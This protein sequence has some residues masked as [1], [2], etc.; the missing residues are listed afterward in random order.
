MT[1][2]EVLIIKIHFNHF[3]RKIRLRNQSLL[4]PKIRQEQNK[5]SVSIHHYTGGK[6]CNNS[7]N[8]PILL[9]EHPSVVFP[10]RPHGHID[11]DRKNQ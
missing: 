1:D 9:V 10:L 5:K 7:H 4:S 6:H 11:I 3:A 8:T 2:L